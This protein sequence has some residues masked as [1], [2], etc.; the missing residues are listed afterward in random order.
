MKNDVEMFA[1]KLSNSLFVPITLSFQKNYNGYRHSHLDTL[2]SVYS[3]YNY[4]L[5][6]NVKPPR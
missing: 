2:E 4:C 3:P 1:E 5:S 6:P